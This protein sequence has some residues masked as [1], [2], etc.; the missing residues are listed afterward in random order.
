MCLSLSLT[1]CTT[2]SKLEILHFRRQIGVDRDLWLIFPTPK[3]QQASAEGDERKMPSLNGLR[4]SCVHAVRRG[5]RALQFCKTIRRDLQTETLELVSRLSASSA[6]RIL[7][8]TRANSA[9]P[10]SSCWTPF[11][12]SG[13]CRSFCRHKRWKSR[14]TARCQ[15]QGSSRISGLISMTM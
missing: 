10:T 7:G 15:S 13:C 8:A 9:L 4:C 5:E 1:R 12:K 11:F 2:A 6:R 14:N 3:Q